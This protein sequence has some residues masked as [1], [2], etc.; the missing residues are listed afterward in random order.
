MI[1][2]YNGNNPGSSSYATTSNPGLMSADD[3]TKLDNLGLSI[4]TL[5][6]GSEVLINDS[7]TIPE[8]WEEVDDTNYFRKTPKE[9][10]YTWA[11]LKTKC[12]NDDLDDIAVGDYK[13]ITLNNPNNW[14]ET[15]RME[16]AG[17]NTYKKYGY[18]NN[19]TGNHIDFIS[20]NCLSNYYNAC[21]MRTTDTNNGVAS[22]QSPFIESEIYRLLNNTIYNFLPT[23][24]KSVIIA[25]PL[26]TPVRY[27]G[28]GSLT[29]DIGRTWCT[30]PHLWLPYEFE[31]VGG[32]FLS[33]KGQNCGHRQYELF[34]LYPYKVTKLCKGNKANWWTASA[35]D[36]NN[37]CYIQCRST[38]D[39][40]GT[41]ASQKA[42]IP[43]CFRV[44][45]KA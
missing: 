38:G 19:I 17:I 9:I 40:S 36:G 14:T 5:P 12:E 15:V 13:D 45:V 4:D 23:D 16:V 27:N 30:F 42:C 3:K 37:I 1:K 35:D 31:V 33:T 8:G 29:N 20:K 32:L 28:S 18:E 34:R 24:L 39:I 44:G 11:E 10:P 25:K 7:T 2:D 43:L 22:Q 41:N 26:M 21:Q 6:I